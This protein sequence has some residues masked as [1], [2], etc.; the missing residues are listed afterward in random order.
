MTCKPRSTDSSPP[1][2]PNLNWAP[3]PSSR[4]MT[5]DAAHLRTIHR[6]LFQDV[7]DWAGQY[8]TLSKGISEF[9]P[10]HRTS[11]YLDGVAAMV[12]NTPRPRLAAEEFADTMA[13]V[14]A[15]S[16]HAHPFREG[17][18]RATNFGWLQS[19]ASHR[20]AVDFE[21]V[22][23]DVWNQAAALV[24]PRPRAAHPHPAPWFRCSPS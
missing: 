13:K 11:S 24:R 3:W 14:Y 9:A 4:P 6:H 12:D 1:D 5:Y 23:A 16:N 22:E 2:K 20:G 19:P 15:W 10:P 17:N 7:Y 8:R 18:G 21:R